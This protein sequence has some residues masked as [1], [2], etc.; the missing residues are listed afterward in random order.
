MKYVTFS[1]VRIW[2][3]DILLFINNRV[4]C[5]IMIVRKIMFGFFYIVGTV[6]WHYFPFKHP[7]RDGAE[8]ST[9]PISQQIS[10]IYVWSIYKMLFSFRSLHLEN[11]N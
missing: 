2:I 9:A 7:I 5:V 4:K 11:Q 10:M 1:E 3:A 6:S 8:D